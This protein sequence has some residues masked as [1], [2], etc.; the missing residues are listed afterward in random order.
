MHYTQLF[1]DLREAKGLSLEQVARLANKH[2]NTVVNVE[3]GRSVK[4]KTIAQLM[5]KMGYPAGSAQMK[6][7]ALLWLE[8]IS[9]IPFSATET[10]ASTRKAIATYGSSA[11]QAAKRLHEALSR[12]NLSADNID[13]LVYAAQ[14]APVL[15]ILDSIRELR[16]SDADEPPQ[17]KVAEDK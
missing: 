5:I 13:L 3:S 16:L 17:L 11:R 1:R 9:G 8:S 14:N 7:V 4:F 6:S 10:E 12:A 2:R 15:N